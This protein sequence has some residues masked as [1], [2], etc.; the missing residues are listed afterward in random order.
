MTAFDWTVLGAAILIGSI[1]GA[2]RGLYL[3]SRTDD[4]LEPMAATVT[5]GPWG[6]TGSNNPARPWNV[7]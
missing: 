1:A 6:S 3:L 7:P 2:L 5:A 4:D